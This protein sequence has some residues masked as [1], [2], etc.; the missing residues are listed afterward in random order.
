MLCV[1][2]EPGVTGVVDPDGMRIDFESECTQDLSEGT[3]WT[4]AF[5]EQR[6]KL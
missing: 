5:R 4:G 1:L 2:S 3:Y 6:S